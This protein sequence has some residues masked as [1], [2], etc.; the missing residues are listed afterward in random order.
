MEC[1]RFKASPLMD[2]WPLPPALLLFC[3]ISSAWLMRSNK[4]IHSQ[5]PMPAFQRITARRSL[6]GFGGKSAVDDQGL[7]CLR[8][9]SPEREFP[10][11]S[12]WPR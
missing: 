2:G 6:R 7:C 3:F 4:S 1:I 8:L 10:P 12:P 9:F 11:D 5:R